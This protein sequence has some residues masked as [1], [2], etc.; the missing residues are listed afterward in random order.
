MCTISFDDIII[1]YARDNILFDEIKWNIS[2]KRFE[3]QLK[4]NDENQ[5]YHRDFL[6]DNWMSY[7]FFWSRANILNAI[8]KSYEHYSTNI[9]FDIIRTKQWWFDIRKNIKE[10]I[11]NCLKCQLIVKSRDIKRD[12]MHLFETWFNKS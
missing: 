8:Y 5:M 1:I 11:R 10:F 7:T 3:D 4:M 9:M 12:E 6:I 2:L